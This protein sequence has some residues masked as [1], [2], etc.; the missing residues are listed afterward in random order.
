MRTEIEEKIL[1]VLFKE[2]IIPRE[3]AD[4]LL[5]EVIFAPEVLQD[6]NVI[7]G[8]NMAR[9]NLTIIIQRMLEEK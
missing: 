1:K 9:D 6:M 3:M 2:D 8:Y 7:D 5:P 4:L